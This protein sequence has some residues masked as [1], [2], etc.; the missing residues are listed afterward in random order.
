MILLR[1]GNRL[2][3]NPGYPSPNRSTTVIS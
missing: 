3:V 2:S 1:G